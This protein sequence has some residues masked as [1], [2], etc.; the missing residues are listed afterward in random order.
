[1][2]AL[3]VAQ[4]TAD[5]AL[6]QGDGDLAAEL[7]RQGAQPTVHYDETPASLALLQLGATAAHH[8]DGDAASRLRADTFVERLR[9]PLR[10]YRR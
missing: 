9:H 7:L 3:V 1:M 2:L 6:G 10:P 5:T 4:V 8:C